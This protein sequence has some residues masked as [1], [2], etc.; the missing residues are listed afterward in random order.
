MSS[1]SSIRGYKVSSFTSHED[2]H[3]QV[4]AQRVAV[5][6]FCANGHE[7]RPT[8]SVD[9]DPADIPEEWACPSCGLP[10]GRDAAAPPAPPTHAPFKTHLGYLKERRSEGECEE[11]LAEA[12]EGLRKRRGRA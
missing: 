7:T 4:L 2:D 12:L 6:Y 10:A 8:F 9:A 3:G 1:A 11:L 5:S